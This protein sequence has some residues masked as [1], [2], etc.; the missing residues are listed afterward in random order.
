[1]SYETPLEV[2][3]GIFNKLKKQ[4]D[5]QEKKILE[6]TLQIKYLQPCDSED[7]L[8]K[9]LKKDLEKAEDT[10]ADAERM[11]NSIQKR[12]DGGASLDQ[13]LTDENLEKVKNAFNEKAGP[14]D[15]KIESIN[16]R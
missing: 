16:R 9:K 3:L 12:K 15:L 1:M 6:L 7:P 13:F 11:L 10:L 4:R 2:M 8:Y 14:E 5:T